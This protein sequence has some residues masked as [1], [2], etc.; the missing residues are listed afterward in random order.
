MKTC[1]RCKVNVQE[2]SNICPLCRAVLTNI[3]EKPQNKTYPTIEVDPY[4]YSIIKRIFIFVS[5][6]SAGGSII[7]NY[8]TYNGV[9]W[10]AITIAAIIYFWIIMTY[11]IRRNRNITSQVLV[12]VLCISILTVIMDYSIGYIG[13][14]VNHVIPEIIILANISVLILAFVNRMYWHTY[15]LN[16]IVIAICGLV[17]GVLW[18]CGLIKILLPTLVATGTSVIVLIAM[19]IFG[20]KTIKSE[21]IRRF[22]F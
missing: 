10:S 6:L 20:D 21:L 19:I 16:Q 5:I 13:W 14:S 22:H 18:L 1:K 9:I 2:D 12:Q 3:G 11:S 8:F 4:K 17:P 7:T 15:V